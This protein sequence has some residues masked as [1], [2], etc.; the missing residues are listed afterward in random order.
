MQRPTP[1]AT[2]STMPIRDAAPSDRGD[3]AEPRQADAHAPSPNREGAPATAATFDSRDWLAQA[4][5]EMRESFARNRRVISFAEYVTLFSAE[6]ERQL[7]SAAQYLRDVFDHFGTEP[8]RTPRGPMIRWKLFDCPWDNGKDALVGQEEVQAAVYRLVC[9]F[10]REGR[11]NRLI[12]LHGPNGSAKSTFVACLQRAMEHYSTRDDGAL[13]KFNWIFPS[14]KLTKGGIGFGGGLEA[15]GGQETFAYLEDELIESKIADEMRDH[16]LLLLPRAKRRE[17]I[18]ERLAWQAGQQ[19][20]APARPDNRA[21]QQAADYLVRGDLSHRNRQIFEAL[22]SSYHG[23][24]SKVL[25]HVQVER[26]FVSRRYRQAA[27][28]VEPQLAVDARSRQ[29]TMD[30]SLGSL[31]P[32][33]QSLTLYEYQGELVDGNRG[34]IDFAD[35][36]KRPLESYKYLLGTVEQGRVSLDVASL[37]LDTVFIGS[38]NEGY[39]AAFKEIPEFQSFKGRMEL[40]RVPYLLDHRVEQRIYDAQIRAAHTE[41]AR[42][43]APHVAWVTALW[44]TLTRM[45]KPLVEKYGKSLSDVVVKLGPMEKAQLYADNI[46]PEGLTTEQQRDL[47]A[48]IEKIARES[49]SYPNYEGRTGASPREMKLMIM[50][51]AQSTRYKCLSPFAVFDELEELVRG[52]TVYEFLKQEPLPGGFHENR[53]FIFQVR[54]RLIDRIDEEVRTSMGLVEERRY[55]DRF[56]RYVTHV[57]F[58]VK[59]EKVPNPITGRNEDPDEQMMADV[60]RIL[61]ASGRRDEFRREVITRIGAWSIDHPKQKPDYEQIFPRPIAELRESFFEERKKQVRKINE[62]LLVLLT[63]GPT[64][65]QPDAAAA[66]QTTLAAMKSRFGYCD[67]CAKDAVLSLVRKRYS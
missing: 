13:Y 19:S 24:L 21:D 57:S 25:R 61:Q 39:L 46:T 48:G 38:S 20:G 8:I 6:P 51:A 22:L 36:L 30:R 34:V 40:V 18:A 59:K 56:E 37:E 11:T 67:D 58:W 60:E 1:R 14:Q 15:S 7:R 49:D 47:V 2:V 62:D 66:A 29:L 64:K 9:N 31:P 33:L 42:H 23:D 3:S 50:N 27:A 43:V 63:D 53:K 44:A 5:G 55:I 4:T 41:T 10:A 45:K 54:D 17:L 16:P 52:V 26:F 32:A 12:L 35:L 65:M 28:T